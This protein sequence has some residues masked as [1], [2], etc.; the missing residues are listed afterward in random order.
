MPCLLKFPAIRRIKRESQ[1]GLFISQKISISDCNSDNGVFFIAD[2][3]T[4]KFEKS[5]SAIIANSRRYFSLQNFKK[6][7]LNIFLHIFQKQKN[8]INNIPCF[9]AQA[10]YLKKTWMG[11]YTTVVLIHFQLGAAVKRNLITN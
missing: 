2:Y 8:Y 10:W 9:S 7:F 5:I 6:N 3:R 11:E 4:M 1:T